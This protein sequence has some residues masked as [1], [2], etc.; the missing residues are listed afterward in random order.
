[1]IFSRS[2]GEI[3]R[4]VVSE[5]Q[6]RGIVALNP[7]G[8]KPPMGKVQATFKVDP[9]SGGHKA[10]IQGA[11]D[12]AT[13]EWTG[14]C[15]Q[16]GALAKVEMVLPS[17]P[18]GANWMI[19]APAPRRYNRSMITTEAACCLISTK[20]GVAHGTNFT[21]RFSEPVKCAYCNAEYCLEYS[22]GEIGRIDNYESRLRAVAQ[23]RINADHPSDADSIIGHTPIIS[24][25]GFD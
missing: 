24:V 8:Q 2:A 13:R 25:L 16:R 7:P 1:M 3:V 14:K 23:W 20:P 11:Q 12:P 19:A 9:P 18:Y 4:T 21:G 6:Q 22:G 15:V 17:P 5:F 10:P